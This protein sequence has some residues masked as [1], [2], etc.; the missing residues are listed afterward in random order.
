MDMQMEEM[1]REREVGRAAELGASLAPHPH[2]STS[3]QAL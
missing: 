1:L 2:V 3:L